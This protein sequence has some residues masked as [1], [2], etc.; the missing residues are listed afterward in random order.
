MIQLL[1]LIA[2]TFV[3]I[4]SLPQ[5]LQILK[6]KKTK[7]ISLPMYVILNIGTF[8]WILYGFLTHQIAIIIPNVI[9][10][11]LNVIILYLKVKHG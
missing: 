11:V 9:F 3:V 10:Q 1:G 6:S 7:D 5:I 8:L 2:G 4:A